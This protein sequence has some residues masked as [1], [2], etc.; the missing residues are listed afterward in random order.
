MMITANVWF[1][2]LQE[3]DVIMKTNIGTCAI[4]VDYTLIKGDAL[5]V[6]KNDIEAMS[7][8]IEKQ[9]HSFE[10][11]S[12]GLTVRLS[13]MSIKRLIM[14]DRKE[15]LTIVTFHMVAISCKLL[16]QSI[17]ES[18]FNCFLI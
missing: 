11:D 18:S 3:L 15:T 9:V 10:I 2:P 17:F 12:L 8:F 6:Q 1:A 5:S 16:N 7:L 13:Q 14:E 4:L